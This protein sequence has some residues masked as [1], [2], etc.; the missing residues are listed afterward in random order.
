M[1][2]FWEAA[3]RHTHDSVLDAEAQLVAQVRSP[4]QHGGHRGTPHDVQLHPGLVL[5][6]LKCEG[7]R[8]RWQPARGQKRSEQTAPRA[9][10]APRGLLLFRGPVEQPCTQADGARAGTVLC[11]VN[12]LR[13]QRGHVL[14]HLRPV[15][16]V[17]AGAWVGG[18]DG[19][20]GSGVAW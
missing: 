17:S 11:Y 4:D 14:S 5:Q 15:C 8:W 3:R 1:S 13:L 9:K 12:Q 20:W 7:A 2:D 19:W 18:G 10:G 6:A 16:P